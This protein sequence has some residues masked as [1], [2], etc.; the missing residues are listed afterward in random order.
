MDT[1]D[2]GWQMGIGGSIFL[3]VLGAILKF[4][5][6]ASPDWIDLQV[7]G[8]ILM[9]AATVG[10]VITLSFWR[11]KKSAEAQTSQEIRR[12]NAARREARRAEPAPEQ[13]KPQQG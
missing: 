11:S 9:I 1:E 13:R 8:V 3:L 2:E 7:T 12:T 10:I 6:K 4:A 5:V